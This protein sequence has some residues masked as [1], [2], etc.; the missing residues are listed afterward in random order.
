MN[1]N[2]C[3]HHHHHQWASLHI[4]GF[5]WNEIAVDLLLVMH[6]LIS[7]FRV[8]AQF[9]MPK[10]RSNRV[11]Y[12]RFN[13][14]SSTLNSVR[15]V[16]AYFSSE[17]KIKIYNERNSGWWWRMANETHLSQSIPK[18]RRKKKMKR[19]S[20]ARPIQCDLLGFP[21]IHSGLSFDFFPLFIYKTHEKSKAPRIEEKKKMWKKTRLDLFP[22]DAPGKFADFDQFASVNQ[23]F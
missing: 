23:T 11:F 2:Y 8:F 18:K 13:R 22:T 16:R 6:S 1:E 7:S 12:V 10:T 5:K 14:I 17:S 3:H 9:A 19:F 15:I 21:I 4:P 20:I